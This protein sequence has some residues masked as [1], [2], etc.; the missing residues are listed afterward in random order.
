M[1]RAAGSAAAG[2]A[3][4]GSA[5]ALDANSF[6]SNEHL[7][8]ALDT[9]V[10]VLLVGELR[11]FALTS[12]WLQAHIMS[13]IGTEFVDVF[14]AVRPLPH[15]PPGTACGQVRSSLSNIASCHEVPTITG[16]RSYNF[17]ALFTNLIIQFLCTAISLQLTLQRRVRQ[18][19]VDSSLALDGCHG[20]SRQ[21]P[22]LGV[23]WM[24]GGGGGELRCSGGVL[25]I[26]SF[27][28]QIL[29]VLSVKF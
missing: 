25:S 1:E 2:G 10:A 13:S 17:T 4:A 16:A 9:R 20:W 19:A 29:F 26:S 21:L 12:P 7:P 11:S 15:S 3:A 22:Y 8:A 23:G 6:L 18:R 24:G 5:V 28:Y 27:G 14:A